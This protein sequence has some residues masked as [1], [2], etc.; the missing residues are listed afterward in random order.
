MARLHISIEGI[1]AA[2]K[3]EAGR[4]LA[5]PPLVFRVNKSL[6]EE[7]KSVKFFEERAGENPFLKDFYKS[8]MAEEYSFASQMF[9]LQARLVTNANIKRWN[10]GI[11]LEDRSIYGDMIFAENLYRMKKL[12][13]QAFEEYM[14]VKE[15][16]WSSYKLKDPDAIVLFSVSLKTCLKRLQERGTGEKIDE[17]YWGAIL[18]LYK[19]KFKDIRK[20]IP[21][22]EINANIDFWQDENYMQDVAKEVNKL[23]K[24]LIK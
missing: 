6:P 19:S 21:V 18:S 4:L 5:M 2:G 13:K 3:T 16:I 14:K 11:A 8:G 7:Y 1:S 17:D 20:R 10:G 9:Y 22:V 15:V 12:N 24:K 23:V